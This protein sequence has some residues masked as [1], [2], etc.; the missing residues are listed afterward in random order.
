MSYQLPTYAP[1]SQELNSRN[2]DNE[3]AGNF[4]FDN[5]K[6]LHQ[7]ENFCDEKPPNKVFRGLSILFLFVFGVAAVCFGYGGLDFGIRYFHSGRKGK[8]LAML[9]F[10]SDG[11][12]SLAAYAFINFVMAGFVVCLRYRK[13]PNIKRRY[14]Y[15]FLFSLLPLIYG[16]FSLIMATRKDAHFDE[17]FG[18]LVGFGGLIAACGTAYYT[19]YFAQGI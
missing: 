15:F 7:Q 14:A 11:F 2:F 9:G 12:Y 16:V 8:P 19:H 6:A 5:E 18:W 4:N 1:P 3:K 17:Y 10:Y 13:S